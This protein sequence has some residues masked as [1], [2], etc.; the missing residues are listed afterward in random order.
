MSSGTITSATSA[1]VAIA[2]VQP[3]ADPPPPN[4]ERSTGA[5]SVCFVL[6]KVFTQTQAFTQTHTGS[7]ADPTSLHARA[8]LVYK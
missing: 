5:L 8:L 7:A 4:R 6:K 2:S 3:V 1:H